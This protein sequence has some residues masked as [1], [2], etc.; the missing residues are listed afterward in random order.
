MKQ[1]LVD[2]FSKEIQ[3]KPPKMNYDANKI[4]VK[5]W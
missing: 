2:T 4:V 3:S 5:H 1:S